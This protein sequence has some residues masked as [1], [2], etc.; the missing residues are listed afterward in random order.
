[1]GRQPVGSQQRDAGG[2]DRFP[3]RTEYEYGRADRHIPRSFD[4]VDVNND[5]DHHDDD[6]LG[7]LPGLAVN[8]LT[9]QI[10]V[11][12]V[13]GILLD[14]VSDDPPHT[15]RASVGP[16]TVRELSEITLI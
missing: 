4:H 2:R 11:P 3:Y 15:G 5:D 10:S 14:H 12:V 13:A 16:L 6:S 8:R 1:V 7:L 9:Q